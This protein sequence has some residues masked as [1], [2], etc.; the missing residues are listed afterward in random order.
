MPRKLPPSRKNEKF[1]GSPGTATTGGVGCEGAAGAGGG[2]CARAVAL[3]HS[4]TVKIKS[5]FLILMDRNPPGKIC[6]FHALNRRKFQK[7]EG[8]KRK[9]EGR[10]DKRAFCCLLP[11][12][13]RL[14][15]SVNFAS[16][17]D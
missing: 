7:A 8:V 10:K 16:V 2:V 5:R 13:L 9:A 6:E 17:A 4:R 11:S 12:A 14:L 3:A 1:I 15:P